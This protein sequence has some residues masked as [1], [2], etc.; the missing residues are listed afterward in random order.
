MLTRTQF[1]S[2]AFGRL[3]SQQTAT[4]KGPCPQVLYG[5][6]PDHPLARVLIT[7]VTLEGPPVFEEADARSVIYPN[8]SGPPVSTFSKRRIGMTVPLAVRVEKV[9]ASTL[10]VPTGP[11]PV[12]ARFALELVVLGGVDH[13]RAEF[14]NTDQD[15]LFAALGADTSRISDFIGNK[16]IPLRMVERLT[17]E[18]SAAE[19]GLAPHHVDMAFVPGAQR[20]ELRVE[21]ALADALSGD[22]Q[23]SWADF[24]A[25]RIEALLPDK[26]WSVLLDQ[27]IGSAVMRR[28]VGAALDAT[29][30]FRRAGEAQVAWNAALPGYGMSV[31]G[32]VVDACQCLWGKIDLDVT[33][34]ASVTASL[35]GDK[36]RFD[37]RGSFEVTDDLEVVCCAVTFVLTLAVG[38]TVAATAD[39]LSWEHHVV[40]AAMLPEMAHMATGGISGMVPT[41]P[42][43]LPAELQQDPNDPAHLFMEVPIP[44]LPAPDGCGGRRRVMRPATVQGHADGLAV[45]GALDLPL[46]STPDLD[47]DVT[48]LKYHPSVHS[49][50]GGAFAANGPG[51]SAYITVKRRGGSHDVEVCDLIVLDSDLAPVATTS[52]Q[53]SSCPTDTWIYLDIPYNNYLLSDV[54]VVVVTSVG[55]R[56]MVVPA[57]A[58]VSKDEQRNLEIQAEAQRISRCYAKQK[59]WDIRWQVDPPDVLAQ[60]TRRLWAFTGRVSGATERVLVR[61]QQDENAV[62][63]RL[64]TTPGGPFR[65]SLLADVP[66]LSIEQLAADGSELDA[67]ALGASEICGVQTLLVREQE[68]HVAGDVMALDP[69]RT[70]DGTLLLVHRSD[71]LTVLEQG[72]N[73][74]FRTVG[75]ISTGQFSAVARLGLRLIARLP[76]G[77]LVSMP[78]G[79]LSSLGPCW[80]PVDDVELLPAAEE[81]PTESQVRDGYFDFLCQRG[82]AGR[83]RRRTE[84]EDQRESRRGAEG[85]RARFRPGLH[86]TESDAASVFLRPDPKAVGA[87][88]ADLDASAMFTRV[89]PGRF[90]AL[91]QSGSIEIL[92]TFRR[93]QL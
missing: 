64:R 45:G 47:I 82:P 22:S 72:P 36:L 58:P 88:E 30:R 19:V 35:A 24:Y 90:A 25:G 29:G 73:Q 12:K 33:L 84:G 10:P 52:I 83:D 91:G 18:T 65:V 51:Y 46:A 74:R 71:G 20:V 39:R 34:S 37:A 93:L 87:E 21:F 62:R 11:Q 75:E 70:A 8:V 86:L 69:V 32:E 60:R 59:R 85:R 49:C 55:G 14:L 48:P 67:T 3:I 80:R 7:H 92:R 53:P 38:G 1:S 78:L 61:A 57:G 16:P 9:G 28:E 42:L 13:V 81:E 31:D 5:I 26:D 77:H 17:K 2:E 89:G 43:S 27:R 79:A 40:A 15:S 41:A 68:H 23:A 54:P 50:S 44:D 76:Q 4:A 56:Q 66:E 63:A 6:P